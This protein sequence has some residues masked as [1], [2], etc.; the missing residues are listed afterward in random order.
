MICK[1]RRLA[2][3][4]YVI[5][6]GA[7]S[8]GGHMKIFLSRKRFQVP[9][10]LLMVDFVRKYVYDFLMIDFVGKHIEQSPTKNVR[11]LIEN[12]NSIFQPRGLPFMQNML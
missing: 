8:D 5:K 3:D 11:I 1:S 10:C 4:E 9:Y 2:L 12:M 7:A 6:D